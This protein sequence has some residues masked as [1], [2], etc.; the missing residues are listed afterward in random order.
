MV[1]KKRGLG[2]GLDAL[3]GGM[4]NEPASAAAKS[5]ESK[6][7]L[8]RLPVDLIQRGRYQPRREFDAD[9][10]RE[11]ADSIAAQGVI[12]PIVVRPVENDRY[13]LIAGE[14]RWRAAQQAGLDEIPVVIKDVTEE[15]AMAM[16]LIENIQ[17]EDLNPLEE[18][19]A[20][21]RLLHEF[22][23]THQE[24]AKAVGKSRTTVTNLL[25]LLELNEEVKQM[26]ESHRLEMGHARALL[27]LQ[28]EAQTQA[29]NQVMKQGLSVRETERLVRRLQGEGDES[30]P[31]RAIP[32]A[33]PDVRRLITD[34]SEKLGAKV[35]LQQGAKGNGKLVIGYNSLDELEGILSHIK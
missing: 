30:K 3:L 31:K 2:R 13:E 20:L 23:L 25:R 11:L 29:A 7:S 6:E 26:V 34:L 14:R 15:A 8:N 21:S 18:A 16:G 5:G 19:N 17:R 4:Q 28:G 24:V 33:D 9:A 32:A 22:G 10:L 1:A 27:G 12:Q 35:D